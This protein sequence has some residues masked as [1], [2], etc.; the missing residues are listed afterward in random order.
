MASK[1][2]LRHLLLILFILGR[3]R[4][5]EILLRPVDEGP[6]LT[7]F[8]FESLAKHRSDLEV[9]ADAR[10]DNDHHPH[11]QTCEP[12]RRQRYA[13]ENPY[14]QI[15]RDPLSPVQ[16]CEQ[17][18][19]HEDRDNPK[20]TDEPRNEDSVRAGVASSSPTNIAPVVSVRRT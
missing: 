6:F 4:R 7:I 19:D 18:R 14:S 17:D 1:F 12:H 13:V 2:R 16:H 5:E 15:E 8:V 9:A 10:D 11:E 20:W 3:T